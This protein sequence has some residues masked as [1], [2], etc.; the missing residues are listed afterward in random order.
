MERGGKMLLEGVIIKSAIQIKAERSAA[1]IYYLITGK[2]SIQTIQDANIY[3]IEIFLGIYKQLNRSVFDG[4]IKQLLDSKLFLEIKNEN[5]QL[6]LHPTDK[7]TDWLKA[8]E[9]NLS[10]EYFNGAVLNNKATVFYQ[11]LLLMVQTLTNV[12]EAHFSFIPVVSN[13]ETEQWVKE[14]YQQLKGEELNYLIKLND[15]LLEVLED[16]PTDHI[17]LFLDRLSGYNHYGK[18]MG[19]LAE[20]Y[21]QTTYNIELLLV[22]IMHKI[23]TRIEKDN[24]QFPALYLIINDFKE[25]LK[26]MKSTK[27][28]Y[29]LF[30]KNN[31]PEIIAKIRKLK[32]NTIYDHLTEIALQDSGFPFEQFVP[33]KTQEEI[34]HVIGNTSSFKLKDIKDRVDPSIS[35][36]QI[37]LTL[38][39]HKRLEQKDAWLST[40]N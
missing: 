9:P 27:Q 33:N 31:T 10:F 22:G 13:V 38:I 17:H 19:Q 21:Q 2:H 30:L 24:S 39:L 3:G 4:I 5:N 29:Q 16:F 11:R 36:F 18:S 35:F 20:E 25:K 7:A 34:L 40:K 1:N 12:R 28:T 6:F 15:E 32:L 26:L 14:V 37:R 8:N 23:I